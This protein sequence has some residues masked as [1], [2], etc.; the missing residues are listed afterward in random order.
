MSLPPHI[1]KVNVQTKSCL[2]T[3]I[4]I[5]IKISWAWYT[6]CHKTAQLLKHRPEAGATGDKG[7]ARHWRDDRVLWLNSW[8]ICTLKEPPRRFAERWWCSLFFSHQVRL[9][10]LHLTMSHILTLFVATSPQPTVQSRKL[11]VSED[12]QAK[13]RTSRGTTSTSSLWRRCLS[14]FLSTDALPRWVL[15]ISIAQ[16]LLAKP[17][18]IGSHKREGRK[19]SP[20]WQGQLLEHI[21]SLLLVLSRCSTFYWHCP[22]SL[23][24]CHF[25]GSLILPSSGHLQVY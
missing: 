18:G 8:T 3:I 22:G 25:L 16:S 19:G 21:L 9:K 6:L 20:R 4:A 17:T 2:P 7:K 5:T 13:F 14:G 10:H 23:I 11:T 12:D 15:S 24:S 1:P